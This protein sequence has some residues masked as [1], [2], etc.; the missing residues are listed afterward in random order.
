MDMNSASRPSVRVAAVVLAAGAGSRFTPGP[1]ASHKLLAPWRGRPLAWWAVSNAVAAGLDCTWV[2]TGAT[3]LAY[4]LP[5]EAETLVN[6][7]WEAGQATSLQVA[8]AAARRAAVD[9]IVVGLAD[10]PL[11]N[12]EAW[13]A[14][15]ACDAA[16]AVAT[17]HGERRNPVKLSSTVWDLLPPSG[18]QGARVVMRT[19]PDLVREVPCPGDPMDIDTR[20]DLETW[21]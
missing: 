21:N 15:A 18:D 3:D 20:E 5:E 10:Q 7:D 11:V 4:V 1:D 14:V 19:R 8:V 2:V 9:A 12:P 6:P 13:R 16:I 17:Y